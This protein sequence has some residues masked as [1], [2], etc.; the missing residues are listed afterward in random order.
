MGER[1]R[2]KSDLQEGTQAQKQ[3][4]QSPSKQLEARD[5]GSEIA[6]DVPSAESP[7]VLRDG[8]F[9]HPANIGQKARVVSQLQRSH[10]NAYVQRL[11]ESKAIQAKL[12]VNPVNDQYEREADRVADAVARAPDTSVQRQ[13]EQ[14]EEL[15]QAKPDG[16]T[17]MAIQRQP[18]EEEEELQMK[19]ASS[20][21][22]LAVQRQPAEE[23]EEELQMKPASS[24][25]Q[26][27]VQRQPEEEEEELQAKPA[28]TRLPQVSP[29]LEARVEA[30]RGSGQPL[31]ESA[32]ASMEPRLGVDLSDVRIHADAE[33]DELSRQINAKAFT[34]G[35]DVFFRSGDYQP[36]TFEGQKLLVHELTHVAQQS[37]APTE[38]A[39]RDTAPPASSEAL[40]E[41]AAP[42][43]GG[44]GTTVARQ[45]ETDVKIARQPVEVKGRSGP[46]TPSPAMPAP[47]VRQEKDVARLAA[48]R[49]MW[50]TAIE[51]QLKEG[52]TILKTKGAG[53]DQAMQA[54]GKI[55]V[56]CTVLASMRGA[57]KGQEPVTSR[58]YAFEAQ[59]RRLGALL[60]PH[61]QAPASLATIASLA[62]PEGKNLSKLLEKIRAG[63]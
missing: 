49:A 30:Q 10:G 28:G 41:T 40:G 55:G 48:I 44:K 61:F 54:H 21:S 12:V 24:T 16:S 22:Q 14:E 5:P 13:D 57:Y 60:E 35:K 52:S 50:K 59:V 37:E 17:P 51:D 42:A 8:R 38:P 33:S 43:T 63:L 39:T 47:P 19:P 29:D 34:T 25:P 26:L 46:A 36:G 58:L 53:K 45:E 56:A 1:Q 15:L 3:V 11:L 9:S 6:V 7:G 27:A 20:T 23:E 2:K 18:E 62:D 4:R 32:R 31:G